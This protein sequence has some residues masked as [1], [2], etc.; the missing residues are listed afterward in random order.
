MEGGVMTEEMD[1]HLVAE[2]RLDVLYFYISPDK[3]RSLHNTYGDLL[4]DLLVHTIQQGYGLGYPPIRVMKPN[5]N[6]LEDK[7]EVWKELGKVTGNCLRNVGNDELGVQNPRPRKHRVLHWWRRNPQVLLYGGPDPLTL[8]GL[9]G[10]FDDDRVFT[11][12][13]GPNILWIGL[14]PLSRGFP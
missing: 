8:R 11:T 3:G 10:L 1:V 6:S 4:A 9:L 13:L 7:V 5:V 14:R 2:F 12:S